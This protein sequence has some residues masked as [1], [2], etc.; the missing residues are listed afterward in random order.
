M[1]VPFVHIGPGQVARLGLQVIGKNGPVFNPNNIRTLPVEDSGSALAPVDLPGLAAGLGAVNLLAS[2]GTLA[3][4]AATYA[5]VKRI[6]AE[7][8]ALRADVAELRVIAD[9][10]RG[11][12]EVIDVRVA[13]QALRSAM[14]HVFR[15]AI[16]DAGID[17]IVLAKLRRDLDAFCDRLPPGAPW[18]ELLA[19]DVRDKL[20]GLVELLVGVR[21][22]V[23]ARHNIAVQGDPARVVTMSEV[24]D[25]L[26]ADAGELAA[27][28]IGKR[29]AGVAGEMASAVIANDITAQFT[30]ASR[31]LEGA[32]YEQVIR[33]L[34]A[35]VPA[36]L[37]V[38]GLRGGRESRSA[39]LLRDILH[40]GLLFRFCPEAFLRRIA[41]AA[42]AEYGMATLGTHVRH[43]YEE[44]VESKKTSVLQNFP[45]VAEGASE[46]DVAEVMDHVRHV[47]Q[48]WLWHTDS[49]LLLR[50][51]VELNG[52]ERGYEQVFW[53]RLVGAGSTE[54]TSIEVRGLLP[55]VKP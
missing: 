37:A 39:S 11:R 27:R 8:V 46:S 54:M 53:P 1:T 42:M 41:T 18:S 25:Y 48:A 5:Q 23:A 55:E 36:R 35:E 49:G 17:L 10:I 29:V 21:R 6:A 4:G 9:E 3:L 34:A 51:R 47:L 28:E 40:Q 31:D 2:V 15:T 32:W 20:V 12:V 14:D 7:V 44:W 30:M 43:G 33:V 50:A 19:T 16:G 38:G 26:G 52:I 22:L 45:V 24:A 13:E